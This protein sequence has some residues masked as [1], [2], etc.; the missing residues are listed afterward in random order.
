MK[1]SNLWTNF[2]KD[3]ALLNFWLYTVPVH[4]I[5]S[6]SLLYL[7]YTG[8]YTYLLGTLVFYFLFGSVGMA[9][10]LHRYWG[11]ASFKMSKFMERIVTTLS[12]FNGYGSIFPWV[13]IHEKGHHVSSD[14]DADPH[15][16]KKGFW[17]SFLYWHKNQQ[18]FDTVIDRRAIVTYVKRGLV[19]DK[20]YTFLNDNH[21]LI[22]LAVLILF[23]L[24]ISWEFSFYCYAI[25]VWF[26]LLNTSLVTSLCHMKWFGYRN[27]DTRDN[28]VNNRIGAILTWGEMLH[29]NHHR[30]WK[31]TSNSTKWSEVDISG[32]VIEGIRTK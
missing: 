9:V 7:L 31:A 10:G 2:F 20:Y 30:F 6:L 11:H 8:S 15:T 23:G 12:V 21:I 32:L 14:T 5:G 16:P 28:S 17:Y 25:G 22:N 4:L 19:N 3:K 24:S 29:N 27:F 1:N 26:T 18:E 13:M